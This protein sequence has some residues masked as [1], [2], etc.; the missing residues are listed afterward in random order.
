MYF[1]Y[2]SIFEN[3]KNTYKKINIIHNKLTTRDSNYYNFIGYIIFHAY[4][5]FKQ[6]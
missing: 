6:E 1:I 3:A 5:D 4:I 2:Y